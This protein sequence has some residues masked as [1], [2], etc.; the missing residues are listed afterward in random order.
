MRIVSPTKRFDRDLKK[1]VK[2]NKDL[3]KL[4]EVVALLAA[5]GKLSLKHKP[6]PLVG[7]WVPSWDCHIEPDW[8]LIY[9]VTKTHVYLFRTGTHSDLFE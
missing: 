7:S 3:S 6:H 1:A 5:K 2:R 4:K 8:I 9:Q